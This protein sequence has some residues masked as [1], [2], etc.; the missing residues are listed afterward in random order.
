MGV[1]T[2]TELQDQVREGLGNRTEK[3][4]LIVRGL[5]V[6]ETVIARKK[7][8]PELRQDP[9]D[10]VTVASNNSYALS[11]LLVAGGHETYNRVRQIYSLAV[12]DGTS[13]YPLD[14]IEPREWEKKVPSHAS[15][16]RESRPNSYTRYTDTKLY[17]WPTPD[18]AYVIRFSYS[19]WPTTI[20]HTA[21]VITVGGVDNTPG[22]ADAVSELEDKDD[23]IIS[24][25]TMWCYSM[26]GNTK[27]AGH[28]FGMYQSQLPEAEKDTTRKDVEPGKTARNAVRNNEQSSAP[29]AGASAGTSAWDANYR[30]TPSW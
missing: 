3:D 23:L 4:A 24:Y 16:D 30:S 22:E 28:F 2:N 5:N 11:T 9:V 26:L 17:F 20:Q 29:S 6:A 7:D 27:K 1:L 14:A 10:S 15:T 21:G 12:I 13:Y 19:L 25:A 18:S 8:F